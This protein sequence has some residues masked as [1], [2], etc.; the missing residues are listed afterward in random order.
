MEACSEPL[1]PS[2]ELDS[3]PLLPWLPALELG[4]FE[5]ELLELELLELEL[6]ELELLSLPEAPELLEVGGGGV[7]GV[8]GGWGWVGLLALGQPARSRDRQA[9]PVSLIGA[10]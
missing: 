1:A 9:S 7:E 5:L 6:L 2:P 10:T 3:L 4:L 8:A